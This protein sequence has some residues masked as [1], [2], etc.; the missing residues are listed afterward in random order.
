[1]DNSRYKMIQ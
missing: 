1:M